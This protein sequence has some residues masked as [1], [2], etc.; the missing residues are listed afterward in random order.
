MTVKAAYNM[1]FGIMAA[2]PIQHQQE[3]VKSGYY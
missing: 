1:R 2:D 3:F